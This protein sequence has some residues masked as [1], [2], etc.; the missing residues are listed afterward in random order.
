VSTNGSSYPSKSAN[1]V[2]AGFSEL[3]SSE[4]H[5]QVINP[6]PPWWAPWWALMKACLTWVASILCLGLVPLLVI[7]PY[8]I[9]RVR[10]SG[11]PRAEELTTD[12]TFLFLS[13][14][15]VI[16][17]HILTFGIVWLVVTEGGRYPF[18]KTVG[19]EWPPSWK[20]WKG[21][22]V[23]AV[24]AVVL[25]GIGALVTSLYGG[26]KT[27]L[28]LLIESSYQAR[29]ATAFLAVATAPLIEELIYRG[30]LYPALERTI[31]MG[32]AIAVVS[33][34]FAGVHVLQYS[35]NLAVIAV[36]T[37]LSISLTMVRAFTGK[38]LPCFVIHLVFNGLQSA[39]LL[40]EPLFDKT[41]K[42]APTTAPALN[43][44]VQVLHYL[45]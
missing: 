35:N 32:F 26:S 23:S 45:N 41:D 31:G 37:L 18:W 28:D 27:Q 38:L 2:P 29:L 40:L 17:A 30:V 11:M 4:Q 36:I 5:P 39:F 1:D 6:E 12:K 10:T 9:Y 8:F 25:L 42:T 20:P 13:I 34:M 21:I 22:A 3:A 33:L 24:F 43:L 19:F 7:L 16:P 44:I 14:L 15:G